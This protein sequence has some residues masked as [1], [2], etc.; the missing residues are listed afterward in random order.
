M[1]LIFDIMGGSDSKAEDFFLL[2]HT[3]KLSL[4][5]SKPVSYYFIQPHKDAALERVLADLRQYFKVDYFPEIKTL[6]QEMTFVGVNQVVK[7]VA[8]GQLWEEDFAFLQ[9]EGKIAQVVQFG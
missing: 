6:R 8:S 4:R 1:S 5:N 2:E 3:S 9:E 7:V